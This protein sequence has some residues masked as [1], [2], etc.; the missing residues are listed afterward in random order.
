[1]SPKDKP[2]VSTQI[3]TRISVMGVLLASSSLPVS[4]PFA[5]S[6]NAGRAGPS[7]VTTIN[8]I[9][10]SCKLEL[11]INKVSVRAVEHGQAIGSAEPDTSAAIGGDGF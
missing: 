8:W 4:E 2:I 3:S 5:F 9:S 11:L 1:M 7:F 10:L 6:S